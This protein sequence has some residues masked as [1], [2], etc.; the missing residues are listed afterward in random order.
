MTLEAT[1]AG[2]ACDFL[3]PR[4]TLLIPPCFYLSDKNVKQWSR[5]LQLTL[6][7]GGELCFAGVWW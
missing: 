1:Q 2:F 6:L 7:E 3:C 4:E 5:A